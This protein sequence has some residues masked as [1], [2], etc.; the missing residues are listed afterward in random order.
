MKTKSMSLQKIVLIMT[1]FLPLLFFSGKIYSYDG[2]DSDT[3][4]LDGGKHVHLFFLRCSGCGVCVEAYPEKLEMS[5][6]VAREKGNATL[7]TTEAEDL[8]SK[9]PST[10][11]VIHSN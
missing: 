11:F 5:G 3:I 9:C 6:G 10:C 4:D 8:V 1:L 2:E 7:T